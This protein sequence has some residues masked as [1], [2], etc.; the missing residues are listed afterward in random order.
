MLIANSGL[1]FLL[2]LEFFELLP[3]LLELP[4]LPLKLKLLVLL[5]SFLTLHFVTSDG[6]G[7]TPQRPTNG[8]P[9]P[10]TPNNGPDDCT[11][12]GPESCT[13]PA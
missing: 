10:R 2:S 3:L 6:P 1:V 9:G 7:D 4:L 5:L 11:S 8:G 12:C 13:P